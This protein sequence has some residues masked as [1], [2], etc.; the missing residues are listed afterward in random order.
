MHCRKFHGTFQS[1]TNAAR[2]PRKR[3]SPLGTQAKAKETSKWKTAAVQSTCAQ[4]NCG[5]INARRGVKNKGWLIRPS[6]AEPGK[7]VPVPARTS[8][9][10]HRCRR[11]A[12]R[13][14]RS[15]ASSRKWSRYPARS[16]Q[17]SHPMGRP[18]EETPK[19]YPCT[20]SV[21]GSESAAH[22]Q[23]VRAENRSAA[24]I[25]VRGRRAERPSPYQMSRHPRRAPRA[26]PSDARRSVARNGAPSAS[27]ATTLHTLESAMQK[28]RAEYVTPKRIVR[29]TGGIRVQ[30][31]SRTL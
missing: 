26:L 27:A 31:C 6:E 29:D 24:T 2:K 17:L 22:R 5:R 9:T 12:R 14:D 16:E 30:G 1:N 21:Q 15:R 28:R 3:S 10:S 25:S 4:R 23:R 18:G 20:Q 11:C 13:K 19:R 7:A 8:S